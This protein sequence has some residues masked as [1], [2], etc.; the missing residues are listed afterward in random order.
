MQNSTKNK[1]MLLGA[2]LAIIIV[3]IIF[4]ILGSNKTPPQTG[5]IDN[6]K[7]QIVTSFYPLYFFTSEIVGDKAEV[8]NITPA[9]AEPHEYELTPQD[10]V[11]IENSQLLIMNGGQLEPWGDKV[12]SVL[13][14]Q[15]I[16]IITTGENIV[17]Q[18][19]VEDGQTI[20][21]PH[22]WLSPVL[23][24]KEVENILQGLI[25]VDPA[26]ASYYKSNEKILLSKLDSLDQQY[27][28]G[29]QTCQKK[30][31][32][33]SHAAFGYLAKTYNLNQV[34]IL[35][36]SPE[37]E[38]SPKKL[39]EIADFAK[40]NNVKYIFFETLVSPK[41][42]ETI[43]KTT[44]AQTLELNPIE[45]LSNAQIANGENYF[46]EMEQN[47]VNLKIALQCK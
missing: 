10:M 4:K 15:S 1:V 21:D 35:G 29:L 31:I 5:N 18:T 42:A 6:P 36:L 2:I 26:N 11:Q 44:G 16:T 47:L 33:T 27:L 25:S 34:P 12:K 23:A 7:L 28:A 30:D 20:L 37:E 14:K 9:G 43:A 22:V 8:Y 19:M 40:K 39:A 41:L 46:T 24:K 38:P 17:D 45:G 3:A 32:I 13:Q